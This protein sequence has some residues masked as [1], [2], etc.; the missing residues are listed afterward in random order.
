MI[1]EF[2]WPLESVAVRGGAS[3]GQGSYRNMPALSDN[4]LATGRRWG[5][6]GVKGA[7]GVTPLDAGEVTLCT[8]TFTLTVATRVGKIWR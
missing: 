7:R 5:R 2:K 1:N 6:Q 4:P 8:R 3:G